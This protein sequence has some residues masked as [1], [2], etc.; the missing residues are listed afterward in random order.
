MRYI[1]SRELSLAEG[2]QVANMPKKERHAFGK[3]VSLCSGILLFQSLKQNDITCYQ[4]GLL[5]DRWILER[6][7]NEPPGKPIM[8]LYGQNS[9]GHFVMMTRDHI[10]PKSLGGVD[11]V[12][13]LRPAC[14]T[15]NANRGN[16]LNA[17]DRKFMLAHPEL[18]DDNRVHQGR[19]HMQEQIS[20][21]KTPLPSLINRMLKPYLEAQKIIDKQRNTMVQ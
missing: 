1:Y 2:F 12:Q 6:G 10:I 5:A 4:C 14:D 18:I 16:A 15:C 20:K 11:L 9:N 8:N 17:A 19:Y 13:N 3:E 7:V 21:M